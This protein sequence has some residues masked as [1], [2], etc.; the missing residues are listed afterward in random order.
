MKMALPATAMAIPER[1]K[2]SIDEADN[3]ISHS[4]C[5]RGLCHLVFVSDA[6][7]HELTGLGLHGR[8]SSTD[9]AA[10]AQ[11]TARTAPCDTPVMSVAGLPQSG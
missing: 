2:V 4:V 11:L 8:P 6:D 9:R 1:G 3:H 7:E 10:V 5:R